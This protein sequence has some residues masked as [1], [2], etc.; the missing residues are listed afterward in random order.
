MSD[1]YKSRMKRVG[2]KTLVMDYEVL[3]TSNI[4]NSSIYLEEKYSY[5]QNS[6]RTKASEAK[7]IYSDRKL[8]I[9]ILHYISFHAKKVDADVIKRA[10]ELLNKIDPAQHHNI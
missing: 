2:I 6:A 1:D 10:R 7:S 5:T 8:F 3:S 9:Q 4:L